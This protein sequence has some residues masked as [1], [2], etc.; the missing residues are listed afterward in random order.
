MAILEA[1]TASAAANGVTS[2]AN[3]I[4]QSFF[5]DH[6]LVTKGRR[7]LQNADSPQNEFVKKIEGYLHKVFG[8][9]G[10]L[11]TTCDLA[12]RTVAASNLLPH[13]FTCAT[14]DSEPKSSLKAIASIH[15]SCGG[16]SYTEANAFSNSLWNAL[17]SASED[18]QVQELL[19]RS[20]GAFFRSR[21]SI[22]SE[23]RRVEG[24]MASVVSGYVESERKNKPAAFPSVNQIDITTDKD[25]SLFKSIACYFERTLNEV[26]VHGASGEMQRECLDNVFIDAPLYEVS[27]KSVFYHYRDIRSRYTSQ[28]SRIGWD[29]FLSKIDRTVLLGDPGGGKSTLSKKVCLELAKNAQNGGLLLP[30]FVHLRAYAA[31]LVQNPRGKLTTYIIDVLSEIAPEYDKDELKSII[32]YFLSVGRCFVTFDGVDEVLDIG[33]RSV[34][35]KEVHEFSFR[36]PASRFLVT[37]RFVGYDKV[38]IDDFQH[39]AVGLLDENCVKELFRKVS[40]SIL[41]LPAARISD[42]ERD[43]IDDANKNAKELLSNPLLLTLIIIIHS[44]RREIPDNRADLYRACADL[45]FDRWDG[46]REINPDLPERYR[47]FD[48]LMHFASLL[49]EKEEY[50]GSMSTPQ[51]E[52]NAKDFFLVDY[53]DNKQGR[54]SEAAKILVEHLTG[55]AW[56]LHEVGDRVFEF[57][58][59]TFLEF[60]YAKHL[61]AE[62]ENIE[63]LALYI[64]KLVLDGNGILPAHLSLQIKCKD[65]RGISTKAV[66]YFSTKMCEK[67]NE[68]LYKFSTEILDYML[69]GA[70]ALKAHVSELCKYALK[71]PASEIGV[72]L[73]RLDTPLSNSIREHTLS[74][75]LTLNTVAQIKNNSHFFDYLAHKHNYHIAD[76]SYDYIESNFS[77]TLKKYVKRSPFMAKLAFDLTGFFSPKIMAAH[78]LRLWADFGEENGR[79]DSRLLDASKMIDSLKDSNKSKPNLVLYKDL[80]RTIFSSKQDLR[81]GTR[82]G[83]TRTYYIAKLPNDPMQGINPSDTDTYVFLL[84]FWLEAAIDIPGQSTY[85]TAI[86]ALYQIRSSSAR[87]PSSAKKEIESWIKGEWSF[88]EP[89][90]ASLSQ[91]RWLIDNPN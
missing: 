9:E 42:A 88:Y 81:K 52:Q 14:T 86:D 7:G 60:F 74:Y 90:K 66:Q 84:L 26:D 17:K 33:R 69:P 47:L 72:T 12:L 53:T 2:V 8:Q 65:K 6:R 56:I 82:L 45:L 36:Y 19:H 25:N 41:Q 55:R 62:Y 21:K 85:R 30:I 70:D 87:V 18:K 49:Y 24:R 11:D 16:A 58:H 50:G 13:L 22:D 31:Y 77:D 28:G 35:G 83:K 5:S 1:V 71:K 32:I 57:T 91:R 3:S 64:T 54:S 61:D 51:L 40:T 59:R 43:F 29:A 79:A 89:T 23:V 4:W 48:L 37:S 76:D 46:Y 38:S 10:K 27:K 67:N 73:F 75:Y 68:V 39:Y 44:K 34:I 63:D 80:A 15:Y 20:Q 78:N